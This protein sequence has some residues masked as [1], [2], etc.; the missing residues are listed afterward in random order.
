MID[1]KGA[2]LVKCKIP[3]ITNEIAKMKREIERYTNVVLSLGQSTESVTVIDD[4]M[5]SNDG[6]MLNAHQ[7]SPQVVSMTA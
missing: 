4:W 5:K 3:T 2:G 7:F 1:I 6:W